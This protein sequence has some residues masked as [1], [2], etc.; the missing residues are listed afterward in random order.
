MPPHHSP[1]KSILILA[2]HLRLGLPSAIFPSGL[3]TKTTVPTLFKHIPLLVV[4]SIPVY[5]SLIQRR[6]NFP[7]NLGTISKFW[8]PVGW[9]AANSILRAHKY[10]VRHRSIYSRHG[11]QHLCSLALIIL[12]LGP[13]SATCSTNIRLPFRQ[14]RYYMFCTNI[15]ST[16]ITLLLE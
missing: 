15:S 1:W 4:T 11:D 13:I 12:S 3:L 8:A 16:G 6:T 9:H 7:P 2:F 10:T 14:T 5:L